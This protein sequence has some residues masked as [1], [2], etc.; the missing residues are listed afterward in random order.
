MRFPTV[1]VQGLTSCF[2][3]QLTLLNCEAE[4]EEI[5]ERFLFVS[6]PMASSREERCATLDVALVEGAVSSP[7]DLET[8]L[9]L[10]SRTR[11]LVAFGTCAMWG[12]IA[13]MSNGLSR[14]SLVSEVY[15]AERDVVSFH[16]QP[17]ERFISVDFALPGC[18]PEKHEIL[19]LLGALLRGTLPVFPRYPVCMECRMREQRCLLIEDDL[20]CLGPL[21]QGGCNARCPSISIPC[22]GCRGPVAEANA[23]SQSDLLAEK[24]HL[25]DA[26]ASRTG[27]FCREWNCERGY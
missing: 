10:R 3:C 18:P 23:A 12:G 11:I 1:A 2:G 5:A 16:P 24:G 8:V 15:G 6:F 17:L 19:Q 20:P 14:A 27:R 13:A 25:A 7:E 22:E 26:V 9:R 21:T 4:L